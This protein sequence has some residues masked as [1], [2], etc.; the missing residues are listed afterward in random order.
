MTGDPRE[1][2]EQTDPGTLEA[3]EAHGG[4]MAPGWVDDTGHERDDADP[5]PGPAAD[6][7]EA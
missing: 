6:E 2:T 5:L 7:P 4:S 3:Q 1:A